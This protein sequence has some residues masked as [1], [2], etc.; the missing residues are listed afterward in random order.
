MN[1]SLF[2]VSEMTPRVR[3]FFYLWTAATQSFGFAEGFLKAEFRERNSDIDREGFIRILERTRSDFDA[4]R[5]AQLEA[6]PD[7]HLMLMM[8]VKGG[9]LARLRAQMK[10]SRVWKYNSTLFEDEH[11]RFMHF[12]RKMLETDLWE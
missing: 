8:T 4:A 7:A 3:H 1:E 10:G 5:N 6:H 9:W 12:Y 11:E 2:K